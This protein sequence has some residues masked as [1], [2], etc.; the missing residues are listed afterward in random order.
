MYKV[1]KR[2]GK[3]VDFD[4][5]KISGAIRSAFEAQEKPYHPDIIDFLALKVTSD[6]DWTISTAYDWLHLDVES[7]VAGEETTVTVTCDESELA[8]LREGTIRIVSE[9]SEKVVHVVQSAAGQMLDPFISVTTGNL[10]EV[11]AEEGTSNIRVQYNT[12]YEYAVDADWLTLTPAGTRALVEW[13][14]YVLTRTANE[15][16]FCG[17]RDELCI[18]GTKVL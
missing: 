13:D 7:G 5:N 3:A 18:V 14:E 9:D 4:I 10:L 11:D 1:Q 2:D 17:D 8:E 16:R 6:Y 12:E 15:S